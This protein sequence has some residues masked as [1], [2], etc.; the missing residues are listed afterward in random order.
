MLTVAVLH[1]NVQMKHYCAQ[2][3]ADCNQS[4]AVQQLAYMQI[5]KLAVLLD[6]E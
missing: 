1:S 2:P 3:S 6:V 5:C 4:S